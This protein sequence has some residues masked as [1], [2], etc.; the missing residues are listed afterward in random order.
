[1]TV[2]NMRKKLVDFYKVRRSTVDGY[3]DA[4]VIA[5]YLSYEKRVK[6]EPIQLKLF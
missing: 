5:V 6:K 2:Y 1:M 4:R 3:H